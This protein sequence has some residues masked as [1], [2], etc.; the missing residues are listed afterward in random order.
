MCFAFLSRSLVSIIDI[1]L[2]TLAPVHLST[3]D[4]P[5]KTPQGFPEPH[6]LRPI[7]V[8]IVHSPPSIDLTAIRSLHPVSATVG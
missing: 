8:T 3:Q 7:A 4:H 1:Y 5:G 6:S 2:T